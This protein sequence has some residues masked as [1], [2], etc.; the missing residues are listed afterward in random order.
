MRKLF[1]IILFLALIFLFFQ[2]HFDDGKC[3]QP[4]M[5]DFSFQCEE[6]CKPTTAYYIDEATNCVI[7]QE[8]VVL[9]E[10]KYGLEQPLGGCYEH[11]ESGVCVERWSRYPRLLDMGWREC[12]IEYKERINWDCE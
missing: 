9:C 6:G 7:Y 1:V 5:Q 12:S 11:I 4:D 10:K 8:I 2:C 3:N